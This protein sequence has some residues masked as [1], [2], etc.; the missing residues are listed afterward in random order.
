MRLRGLQAALCFKVPVLLVV[1]IV[2]GCSGEGDQSGNGGSQG[3]G[4]GSGGETQGTAP[5]GGAL[6]GNAPRAKVALGTIISVNPDRRRIVL[7]PSVK[8]QG[9]KRMV[10]KVKGN[11]KISLN[12]QP[13][14]MAAVKQGQQA[15]I[16][17]IVKNETNRARAV[18]LI[19]SGEGAG[20]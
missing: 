1:L 19:S 4:G 18:A 2:A 9:G 16:E 3:G 11:A 6:Q 15:Q 12:D 5:Q 8:V 20:G 14:E 13:A 10:F 17:Y 7:R